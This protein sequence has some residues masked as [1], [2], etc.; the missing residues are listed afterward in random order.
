MR[1]FG[2]VD[3]LRQR[4]FLLLFLGQ[5]TSTIGDRIVYVAL[6]LYVTDIGSPTDVGIVLAAA[7]FPLVAFLLFGGVWA[8]RLPRHKVMIVTDLARFVLHAVLAALIFTDAIEIWHIVVIEALFGTAEAFF[9]PA[10]T[11]LVPQTVPEERIQDAKAATGALETVAEFAGPALATALVLGLGA[12]WAFAL[13]ALTFLV[14]AAFLVAV[15]PRERG[16]AEARTSVARE[17][18]EGWVEVRTRAWVW[19]TLVVFSLALLLCF[20]P[21][22]TLGPTVAEEHYGSTGVYGLLA[23]A[24]GVGTMGGAVLGFR[25]RPRHP[26]R[27]GMICVVFWPAVTVG[28]AAGLTLWLLVPLFLAVG[29][30]LA[31]FGVWWE[32]ALAERIP[33]SRL[34]RV[35]SYDWMMSLALLPVG[36]LLAGPLGEA[37]G[38]SA[39]LAI[40]SGLAT[41]ALVAG[42]LV[43][44]TWSYTS[45]PAGR[46]PATPERV[47]PTP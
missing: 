32:T 16:T 45:R 8:D 7:T 11:G 26:M 35:S 6:A 22:T 2:V 9:R 14:S 1:R 43:R 3:I 31:L 42:V 39:L 40:G 29:V 19:V 15:R 23:A 13:D 20:A 44:E 38:E 17:L 28:F 12:G 46:A 25:L 37:L 41:R 10:Y 36:Y 47:V 27:I 21:Y 5:A 30:G 24:T 34:S 4:N 33:P 18:R